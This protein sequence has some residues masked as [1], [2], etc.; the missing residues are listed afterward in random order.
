MQNTMNGVRI[1]TW[2]GG[3]G[4]VQGVSFS[5]IQMSEVQL[6]IVIDQFYCDKSDEESNT[7]VHYRGSTF[8]HKRNIYK[9]P[10]SFCMQMIVCSEGI[11][12]ID[13]VKAYSRTL[14]F[15]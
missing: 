2:Q 4:S 11:T 10:N 13:S 5:N 9:K 6:P 8:E 12:L 3:A 7:L 15:I 14:S 1:K